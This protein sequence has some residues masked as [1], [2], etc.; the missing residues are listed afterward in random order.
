MDRSVSFF[1]SQWR[2][3][4]KT[5]KMTAFVDPPILADLESTVA[6]DQNLF[7]TEISAAA[8]NDYFHR[9]KTINVVASGSSS[10]DSG[11][12]NT[13]GMSFSCDYD[14]P[15]Q[16]LTESQELISTPYRTWAGVIGAGSWYI[17]GE[18]AG[19]G[20]FDV[21]F[22]LEFGSSFYGSQRW[23]EGTV[24]KL[25]RC[26]EITLILGE[27]GIFGTEILSYDRPLEDGTGGFPGIDYGS[28]TIH[29]GV[30]AIPLFYNNTEFWIP[31]DNNLTVN[32][33]ITP[34]TGT[35][36]YWP[37]GDK[38]DPATGHPS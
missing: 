30:N 7:P 32:I 38:I 18:G 35:D 3:G 8:L 1:G 37:Y 28:A 22:R 13:G 25:L 23:G 26:M 10:Y 11:G 21:S 17:T 29:G 34:G 15:I 9:L 20:T 24:S 33:A 16:S 31:S 4:T 6:G 14:V 5:P 12:G 27:L 2:G 19:T 36:V